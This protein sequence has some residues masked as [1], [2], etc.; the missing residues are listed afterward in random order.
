MIS[1]VLIPVIIFIAGVA[2]IIFLRVMTRG[3][4]GSSLRHRGRYASAGFQS[5]SPTHHHHTGS[6]HM[7]HHQHHMAIHHMHH[8]MAMGQ[9][10][11][12]QMHHQMAMN[13]AGINTG[14]GVGMGTI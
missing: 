3:R 11:T 8:Q 1:F 12:H 10:D 9:M 13:N 6:T 2:M 7:T 14:M 4:R 5:Q